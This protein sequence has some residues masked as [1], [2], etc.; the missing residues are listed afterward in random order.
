[1]AALLPDL[2][3]P[4]PS[5]QAFGNIRDQR[6][7]DRRFA[8][9]A[10][11]GELAEVREWFA[12][13]RP[14]AGRTVMEVHPGIDLPRGSI[15]KVLGH[16]FD[17]VWC[18]DGYRFE[19]LCADYP[20]GWD[21]GVAAWVQWRQLQLKLEGLLPDAGQYL[22]HLHAFD[23]EERDITQQVRFFN[24]L[25]GG[26]VRTGEAGYPV[27]QANQICAAVDWVLPRGLEGRRHPDAL[28]SIRIPE[29]CLQWPALGIWIV[30]QE[31]GRLFDWIGEKGAP[32]LISHLWLTLQS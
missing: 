22:L 14:D 11:E 13:L 8:R 27:H 20:Q 4:E 2:S 12:S 30:P 6:R 24:P 9:A 16:E 29:A 17:R 18:E 31:K 5:W 7:W 26:M 1:V 3:L 19:E 32:G 10:A 15:T 21:W 25:D 23:P 28:C